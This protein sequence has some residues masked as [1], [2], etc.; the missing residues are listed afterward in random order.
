[1]RKQVACAIAAL[2]FILG[3]STANAVPIEISFTGTDLG[4]SDVVSGGFNFETDLLFRSTSPGMPPFAAFTD[5]QPTDPAVPL[6]YFR[7]GGY[8]VSFPYFGGSR[9]SSIQFTDGC[10]EPGCV[11][12]DD[13]FSLFA[14]SA[15]ASEAELFA[16]FTGTYNTYTLL[17]LPLATGFGAELFDT[18]TVEPTAA[19]TLPLGQVLGIFSDW[20]YDCVE[21]ICSSTQNAQVTFF[22]DTVTRTTREVPEPGTLSLFSAALFSL[23]ML[24]RRSA[25]TN[26]CGGMPR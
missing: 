22:T 13:N 12:A 2:A 15:D 9:Y 8:D 24:R 23:L 18:S 21:G 25:C 1:M 7:G 6:A 10:T 3:S 26:A 19:L 14:F 5:W 4:G 20:T 17:F 11:S 16:G